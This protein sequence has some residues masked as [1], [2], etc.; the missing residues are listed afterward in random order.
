[1][2]TSNYTY[3]WGTNTSV[4]RSFGGVFTVTCA[5]GD[6]IQVYCRLFE[7]NFTVTYTIILETIETKKSFNSY[8]IWKGSQGYDFGCAFIR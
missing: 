6:I 1:M 5:P 3:T 2:S 4:S 8:G 7:G